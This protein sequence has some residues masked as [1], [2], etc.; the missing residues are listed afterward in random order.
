LVDAVRRRGVTALDVARWVSASG[1][2]LVLSVPIWV[3]LSRPEREAGS[4]ET[5]FGTR[6]SAVMPVGGGG[7]PLPEIGVHS[8]LLSDQIKLLAAPVRI[9]IEAIG[10]VADVVPV[11]VEGS[12]T[13]VPRDVDEVGWYRFGPRPGETGSTLLIAHV[14]SRTQGPG[15]FFRL[16]EMQPGDAITVHLADRS[17]ATYTVV[18]RRA[19]RKEELSDR[20]FARDG[21]S[22]LTLVTCGGSFSGTTRSYSDNVVVY[23]IPLA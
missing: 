11:G 3:L 21:P 6:A 7:L 13:E 12:T 22:V 9:R 8:A 16:R 19:Y 20:V 10:L 4:L 2:L 1:G 23:A 5:L 15:A 14:D 18:A 17:L